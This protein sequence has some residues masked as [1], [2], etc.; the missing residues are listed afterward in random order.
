MFYVCSI[1]SHIIVLNIPHFTIDNEFQLSFAHSS[2]NF[3]F[4]FAVVVFVVVVV[5]IVITLYIIFVNCLGSCRPTSPPD[6][7][8][9]CNGDPR[10]WQTAAV[11]Q[12]TA[13]TLP[14]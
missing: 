4:H 3:I 11:W 1:L 8:L 12:S 7:I 13:R 5:V 6:L 9:L 10:Y 14:L 2:S